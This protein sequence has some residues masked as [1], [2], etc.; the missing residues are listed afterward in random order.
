VACPPVILCSEL[1]QHATSDLCK[2]EMCPKRMLN[3]YASKRRQWLIFVFWLSDNP[4]HPLQLPGQKLEHRPERTRKPIFSS[5]TLLLCSRESREPE[6]TFML[7]RQVNQ[8]V[9]KLPHHVPVRERDSFTYHH[10]VHPL[11]KCLNLVPFRTKKGQL[12][13]RKAPCRQL[14]KSFNVPKRSVYGL[15]THLRASSSRMTR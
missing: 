9:R 14:P 13:Y 10:P 6:S 11:T 4:S 12:G 8:S 3:K 2:N 7:R 15:L 5:D 1:F